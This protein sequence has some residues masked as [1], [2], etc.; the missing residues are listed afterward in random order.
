MSQFGIS[1]ETF[2]LGRGGYVV[3]G[4]SIIFLEK[5]HHIL[6]FQFVI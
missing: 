3:T 1:M 6:Q 5:C 4:R 2:Y